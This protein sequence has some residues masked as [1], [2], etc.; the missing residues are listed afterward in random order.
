MDPVEKPLRI[1]VCPRE[2]FATNVE[3]GI[4]GSFTF[5]A[6]GDVSLN[7]VSIYR[8]EESGGS[9]ELMS[10]EGGTLVDVVTPDRSLVRP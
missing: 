8:V 4:L 1:K 6:N 3:D 9:N 2:L 5:D 10:V 7:P